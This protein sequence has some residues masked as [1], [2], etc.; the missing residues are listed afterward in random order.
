MTIEERAAYLEGLIYMATIDEVVSENELN[1]FNQVG[2]IYGISESEIENIKE[3]VLNRNKSLKDILAPLKSRSAK[4]AF[5]YE[6][7]GLCYADGTYSIAEKN[8]MMTVSDIL[9]IEEKKL[10]EIE[11]ILEESMELQKRVSQV[12]EQE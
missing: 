5:I 10:T 2:A 9:K 12:L 3:S 6:L 7:I 8:G 11:Q 1:Q 4:L